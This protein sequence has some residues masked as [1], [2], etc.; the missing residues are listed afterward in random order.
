[1]KEKLIYH[2]KEGS[3]LIEQWISYGRLSPMTFMC[4][5]SLIKGIES[6]RLKKEYES[7]LKEINPNGYEEYKKTGKIDSYY[8]FKKENWRVNVGKKESESRIFY[9]QNV[10]SL[11]KKWI[12]EKGDK[13]ICPICYEDMPKT[14]HVHHIDG[15]HTNNSKDNK[16]NICASC[17]ALTYTA[18]K[19]LRKLWKIRHEKYKVSLSK[20][21]D[22]EEE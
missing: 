8:K 15:E 5:P 3:K 7:I 2:K 10:S 4:L 11:L 21:K 20:R 19:D 18:K 9:T 16:V 13:K 14:F 12:N 6:G 1:M 22:V 17:H